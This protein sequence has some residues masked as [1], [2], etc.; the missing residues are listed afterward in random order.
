MIVLLFILLAQD[1]ESF[2]Q[3]VAQQTQYLCEGREDGSIACWS[4]RILRPDGELGVIIDLDE[5]EWCIRISYEDGEVCS[6]P[7]GAVV[8]DL[9]PYGGLNCNP[10]PEL[11]GQTVSEN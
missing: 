2:A 5:E 4:G 9:Y 10:L 3:Y 11:E 8:C 7:E 1:A 6:V